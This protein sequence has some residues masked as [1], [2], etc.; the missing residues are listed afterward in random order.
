MIA[1]R[2]L[3]SAWTALALSGLGACT[4]GSELPTYLRVAGGEPDQGR[5]LIHAFGCGTCHRIEG[6]RG[7]RGTVGPPLADYAERSLLAGILPNTPRHLVP[8][9]MDPPAFDPQTGMPNMGLTEP[10]ARHIAAYLYSLGSARTRVY[11]PYPPL[12]L[13]GRAGQAPPDGG[14]SAAGQDP[15]ET[16]PRT[17]FLERGAGRR[18]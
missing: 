14:Q 8:W 4:E 16:T 7:A 11:P 13:G 10:E 6:I 5:R 15:A 9:L 18:D 12:E 3:L 2:S 17:R 1:S